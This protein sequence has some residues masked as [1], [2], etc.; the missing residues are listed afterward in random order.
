VP[1]QPDR[2]ATEAASPL[3]EGLDQLPIL[4]ALRALN[5]ADRAVPE[6][7]AAVV[8]EVAA[9]VEAAVRSLRGGGRLIYVGAGT[10]G[11]L[12]VLDA[13]E[14]PPTFGLEPGRVV[15]VIAGGDAALRY[16]IEGAEDDPDAGAADLRALHVDD[17]DTVLGISASGSAPYVLG[18][19]GE[20]GERGAFIAGLTTNRPCAL[21]AACRDLIA[22]LVG[23]EAIGGSTRMLSG[24]AQKL[25]LN[26][27]STMTMVRLGK[28]Y[29]NQMVDVRATNAKLLRRA[30]RLVQEL[31]R[32]DEETA[33]RL[34]DEAEGEAKIAILMARA[35][36]DAASARERL[37]ACEG[38]LR[39]A[40]GA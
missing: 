39:R 8:P 26:M 5:A 17:R 21:E 28:T 3:T 7:V 12:G 31:G 16:S 25:V 18:A 36:L 30:R 32:V 13:A 35:G 40:L 24:T 19:L 34:L 9:V 38:W 1:D 23:P 2:P 37:S 20:A 10:S 6:C 33:E 4:D 27:I 15:G 29:G 22:P 11:R 14:I